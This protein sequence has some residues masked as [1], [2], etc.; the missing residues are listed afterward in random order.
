MTRR[1][2]A[3]L[4]RYHPEY[5]LQFRSNGDVWARPVSAGSGP[6]GLLYLRRDAERAVSHLETK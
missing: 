3:I 5:R 6:F 1:R 2:Q 4:R